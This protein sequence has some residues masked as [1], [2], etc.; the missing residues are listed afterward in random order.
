MPEGYY[1]IR[2]I[3]AGR[4]GEKVK[5]WVPGKKAPKSERR[6]KQDVQKQNQ[7][8]HSAVRHLA[9]ILNANFVGGD[10]DLALT[11]DDEHLLAMVDRIG[12]DLDTD[13]G[14]EAIWKAAKHEAENFRRRLTRAA[15]KAGITCKFVLTTADLD[16]ETGEYVRVH[17]HFICPAELIPLVESKWTAGEV[18]HRKMNSKPD[19]IELARY[20]LAQVRYVEDA[21]KYTHTRNLIMPKVTD[22]IA[23]TG[24]EV[25]PPKGAIILE[26][27][28]WVPGRPQYIRYVRPEKAAQNRRE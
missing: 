21:K 6:M 14:K 20:L 28:A 27:S 12:V 11:Y 8:L 5:F 23:K 16:G 2:T 1:V 25:Q 15:E 24:K 9:R 13:E 10:G 17:H 22:R 3:E 4:V 18:R 26:R 7:N 19:H